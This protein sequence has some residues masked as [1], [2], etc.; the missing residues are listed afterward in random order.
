M[1]TRPLDAEPSDEPLNELRNESLDES[2]DESPHDGLDDASTARVIAIGAS[3]GGLDALQRFFSGVDENTESSF[4]VIQHLSPDYKS[5]MPEL[6]ARHTSLPIHVVENDMRVEP[7][8]IYLI[9]PKKNMT[10]VDGRL[11]LVDKPIG[12]D[13][14]LPIDIFFRSLADEAVDRAV[15]VVL[16][17]TGSDGTRGVR[18]IKE[19]DGTVFVQDPDEAAF[20]GMPLSALHTGLVDFVLPAEQMADELRLFLEH[21]QV[22][23]PAGTPLPDDD[24]AWGRILSQVRSVTGIDFASYRRPT[25]WRRMLR[26]ISIHRLP[27]LHAYMEFLQRDAEEAEILARDFLIGV[28]KFFRDPAAWETLE[29][30]VLVPLLRQKEQEGEPFKAWIAGCS[31]GEEAYT[32]AMLLREVV[33]RE[34]LQVECKIFATDIKQD[35][36][37]V[38]GKGVYPESLVGDVPSQRVSQHFVRSG[39]QYQVTNAIRRMVIFSKHDLTRDP[40]FS[41]M[42]LVICRNVLIYFDREQQQRLIGLLRYALNQGGALFLGSSESAGIHESEFDEIDRRTKLFRNRS[43]S[44]RYGE[45]RSSLSET[46][47]SPVAPRAADTGTRSGLGDSLSTAL[48]EELGVV[49]VVVDDTFQIG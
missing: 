19:A 12:H 35:Y 18:A 46:R 29:S 47:F 48:A 17:G 6:L 39:D 37:E 4:V 40:P 41:R 45:A 1:T 20:D 43:V 2:L 34:R 31:T 33:E 36:L 30:E 32:L 3:A 44:K 8:A 21:P 14:N 16:S 15:A 9:P 24:E 7:R 23:D 13:L 26:R 42:D 28:T 10:I 11:V 22:L 25:L 38:G 27:S 49:G 5:M